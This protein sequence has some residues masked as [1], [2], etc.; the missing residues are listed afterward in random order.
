[1]PDGFDDANNCLL[2]VI[3]YLRLLLVGKS[4]SYLRSSKQATSYRQVLAL[5]LISRRLY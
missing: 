3:I 2:Y 5:S 1:M 4:I